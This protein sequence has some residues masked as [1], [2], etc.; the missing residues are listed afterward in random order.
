MPTIVSR[1]LL[2]LSLFGLALSSAHAKDA[3]ADLYDAVAPANS[4]F[5]RVLNLSAGSVDVSLSSKKSAQKVG[6]GQLGAYRFTPPGKTALSIGDA[7][8]EPDLQANTASTLLYIDGIITV[9]KDSYV[10]EPK[11][12][13][14]AFYN[15]TDTQTAL[16][17]LDGKHVVVEPIAKA[18]TGGRMVNEFKIAFAAYAGDQKVASF[19]EMFL[20]KGRSYSYV[21]LPD[22]A[23][24]RTISQA[25]AIDPTE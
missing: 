15:M 3:N 21:L 13:Q 10:N 4:A 11:K 17:T 7:K 25:N 1:L 14:L 8:V 24:Y 5:V 9:L 19:D 20:K 16:K 22:G 6:P 23:G 12:A 2:A 18:Q